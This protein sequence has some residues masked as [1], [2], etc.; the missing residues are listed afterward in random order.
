MNSLASAWRIGRRCA[1]DRGGAAA[2]EFALL[3]PVLM[4]LLLGLADVA[5]LASRTLQVEAAARTG[6][7]YARHNGWQA[8]A[9]TRAASD[10]LE[11]LTGVRAVPRLL[12]GCL[13]RDASVAAGQKRCAGGGAPG[14]YV[15]VTVTAASAPMLLRSRA[16][17]PDSVSGQALVRIE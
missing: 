16:L 3:M 14:I 2:V 9:I 1:R 8:T 6:A 10:G 15:E 17:L 7:N 5:T 12:A 13:Q 4:V 11:T